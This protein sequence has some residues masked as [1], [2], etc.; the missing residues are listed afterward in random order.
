MKLFFSTL[1]VSLFFL[2]ARSQVFFVILSTELS[3][4]LMPEHGFLPGKKFTIY[5]T[6]EKYDFKGRKFRVELYDQR[7]SLQLLHVACSGVEIN[8]KSEF[9]GP[10]GA[11]KVVE[12][13]QHLL[14]ASGI[15]LDSTASDTI[16]VNLEALDSRLIG[17]GS[18]T[19]HG[20]CQMHITCPG[21]S[22]T[23][24][25]DITDKDKHSPVG[26]NA[27]VTRKTATR[28]IQS[29]SIREVIE[30]FLADLQKASTPATSSILN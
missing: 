23:Y 5:P 13:F 3:K 24:C 2:P 26:K 15:T 25:I 20:L 28:I 27:F 7:D 4:E 22:Q 1:L 8:N 30:K 18:I 11:G 14:P 29:A 6:L 17:F 16:K 19:A 12:Y 10:G 9:A 21:V